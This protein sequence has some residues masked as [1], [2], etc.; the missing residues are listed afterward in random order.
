M[1]RFR[2]VRTALFAVLAPLSAT[3]ASDIPTDNPHRSELDKAV[4]DA[5]AGFFS[6][7]CRVGLSMAIVGVEGARFYDYGSMSRA[8]A[9]LAS[10]ATVYELASVTKTF[11]GVAAAR[12][13]VEKRMALDDDFRA[14]LP[15]AYPNLQS[16][17]R[18]VTLR[19]LA[20]HTSGMPRDI[21]DTDAVMKTPD[22]DRLPTQLLAIEQ[23]FT[24]ADFAAALRRTTLRGTPGTAEQY[25]NAGMK[26]IALGL[27][28]VYRRSFESLLRATVFL[29]LRMRDTGF[30]LR[31]D[32]ASRLA[33]AYGR[34]R[35]P[36]PYHSINAGASW[37]LYST[38]RD[39]ARYV[40]WQLDAKDPV[41]ARAHALIEGDTS[42]GKGMIWNEAVDHGEPMLWHGGGSF[43]MSSQVVLYPA[44]AQGFVL[45]AN[46]A[47]AGTE[48]ALKDMA[49]A[50]HAQSR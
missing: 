11:T 42:N 50:V 24:P 33:T 21:P 17:G 1:L 36:T 41:I 27:E 28:H 31:G 4:D 15:D 10:P 35:R 9:R 26:V 5:A 20:A 18:P 30:A 8:R 16:G 19:T 48:S 34:N 32:Q 6:D 46:D 25:S 12:A 43:G 40:A 29:P 7:T 3:P 22:F 13:L 14:Y 23:G 39:M 47:C 45:L 2:L 44:S 38:T 37:G 49:A